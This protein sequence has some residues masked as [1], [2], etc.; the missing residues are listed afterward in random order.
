MAWSNCRGNLSL[1]AETTLGQKFTLLR[2]GI[3]GTS[4]EFCISFQPQ[5]SM[6]SFISLGI[7][8]TTTYT[9]SFNKICILATSLGTGQYTSTG[10]QYLVMYILSNSEWR[11]PHV[12]DRYFLFPLTCTFGRNDPGRNFVFYIC[13]VKLYVSRPRARACLP[14]YLGRIFVFYIC[15]IQMCTH[16]FQ[17]N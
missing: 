5:M 13:S 12:Y 10:H 15:T 17:S 2:Y 9:R 16:T 3:S 4:W 7:F 6:N 1:G 11:D 14:K 8:V